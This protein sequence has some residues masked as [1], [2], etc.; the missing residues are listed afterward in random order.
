MLSGFHLRSTL[1]F[2]R[3][4]IAALVLLLTACGG[5]GGG[6]DSSSPY[7]ISL[8]K[9]SLSYSMTFTK[10]QPADQTVTA[11]FVGEGVIVG[12]PPGA[13]EAG[14]LNISLQSS[15]STSARFTLSINSYNWTPGVYTTTVRFVTGAEGDGRVAQRDLPVTFTVQGPSATQP[16]V[17]FAPNNGVALTSLPGLSKL[18][19]VVQLSTNE[20]SVGT[21]TPSSNAAWLS[22][23]ATGA[24]VTLTADP[25]SLGNGMHYANVTVSSSVSGMSTETIRVGLF[26]G[27]SAP[28]DGTAV[29]TTTTTTH[30][31]AVD[32]VRPWLYEATGTGVRA[33][34]IYTGA[35]DFTSASLDSMPSNL[36]VSPDGQWLFARTGAGSYLKLDILN[37]TWD[38]FSI[39]A[40]TD[41]TTF[42]Y[43]RPTGHPLLLTDKGV[44]IDPHSETLV[45][46]R[47]QFYAS[48]E[49][50][51]IA[52]S[53]DL[54]QVAIADLGLSG[55][56]GTRTYSLKYYS[57]GDIFWA[58]SLAG[59]NNSTISFVK[60]LAVNFDGSRIALTASAPYSV[61]QYAYTGTAIDLLR[62]LPM[63]T[64]GRNT[65]IDDHNTVY[66]SG[67]NGV[68]AYGDSG[69]LITTFPVSANSGPR[70]LQISGD[71]LMLVI[72]GALPGGNAAIYRTVQ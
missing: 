72:P 21:L 19:E 70:S 49:D 55:G 71:G 57:G 26:V 33:L 16:K 60:D 56:L 2:S 10:D 34:N 23:G 46:A 18:S 59:S 20:S 27:D 43:L 36:Q 64:Y 38:S 58:T 3:L 54:Q 63:D 12:F 7:S 9:S 22:A 39:T 51:I 37:N 68:K 66:G 41:S 44:V 13:P 32:P 40:D 11:N 61:L 35:V 14:W 31:T 6:G 50:I 52:P 42:H 1:S 62:E 24:A 5:G 53:G 17:L 67:N 47:S 15:T 45:T 69:T 8:N 4:L 29:P 48:Y 25:T 28:S 65:V 30:R